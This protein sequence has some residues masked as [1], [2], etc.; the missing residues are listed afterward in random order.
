M[1]F[2]ILESNLK[3]NLGQIQIENLKHEWKMSQKSSVREN[4]TIKTTACF[5]REQ[6]SKINH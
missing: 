3:G 6:D 1:S 2:D 4:L 5:L